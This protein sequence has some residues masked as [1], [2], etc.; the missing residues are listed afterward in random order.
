MHGLSVGDE[1]T[2]IGPKND[3]ELSQ[4][5]GRS[6]LIAGGI[7]ITPI[8][9][10]ACELDRRQA[11]FFLHYACRTP[12]AMAYRAEAERFGAARARLYFDGGRPEDGLQLPAVLALPKPGAHVYVCGPRPLIDATIATAR[13]IGWELSQIHFELFSNGV[14][15]GGNRLQVEL[16]RSSLKLDV[17]PD[18]TILDAMIEAGCD[19]MFDCKRGECGACSVK[20]LEGEAEHR[21]YCLSEDERADNMMCVCV[22]RAHSMKLVLDA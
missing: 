17:R 22:S 11:P 13:E 3:F 15:S 16:R 10:M 20:V 14:V 4:N 12:E 8:L 7:G 19:P 9:S 18:Q 21:D 5:A 2:A 1:L 6:I